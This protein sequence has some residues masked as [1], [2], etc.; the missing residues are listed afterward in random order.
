MIIK[1]FEINKI[2]PKNYNYFLFYGENNGAK[3]EIIDD[4][5]KSYSQNVQKY[6]ESE[7]I[8]NKENFLENVLNKSLFEQEKIIIV[9]RTTDKILD[10]IK[11]IIQKKVSEIKIILN[12][13]I[14]EKKSKLRS[15]F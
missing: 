6:E 1:S 11:E 15:F 4:F 8:K 5:K 10:V 12:A 13:G 3:L 2:N 9:S 7:I 14:L